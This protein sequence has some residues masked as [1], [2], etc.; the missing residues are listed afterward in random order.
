VLD[1]RLADAIPDDGFLIPLAER[2]PDR[3]ER[4]LSS[5]PFVVYRVRR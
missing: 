1:T 2:H 4:L 5:G 3:F